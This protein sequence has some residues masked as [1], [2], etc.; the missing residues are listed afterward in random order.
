MSVFGVLLITN[1]FLI[2]AQHKSIIEMP[3]LFLKTRERLNLKYRLH[4]QLLSGITFVFYSISLYKFGES[5][6]VTHLFAL[7]I[8]YIVIDGLGYLKFIE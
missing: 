5:Y 7:L 4:T 2:F 1:S 3:C 6:L 8:T